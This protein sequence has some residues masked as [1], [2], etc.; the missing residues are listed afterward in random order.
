M[1]RMRVAVIVGVLLLAGAV[2]VSADP[3]DPQIIVQ[4][5]LPTGTIFITTLGTINLTFTSDLNVITA[6][7]C[8]TFTPASQSQSGF[9]EMGC[10]VQNLTGIALN[11]LSFLISPPQSPL[12]G[13]CPSA[14]CA[15]QPIAIGGSLLIFNFIPGAV[16]HTEDMSITF[17]GFAQG[18]SIQMTPIPEPGT[19]ALLATG[20][21]VLGLRRRKR[22]TT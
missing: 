5:G 17:A 13:S 12:V 20:L 21:G 3:I 8:S 19:L 7:G 6:Q 22:V 18:T 4:G 1:L 14:F 10:A 2:A 15:T 16:F 9:D 11:G